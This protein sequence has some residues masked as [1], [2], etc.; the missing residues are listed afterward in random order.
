MER[1]NGHLALVKS[2]IYWASHLFER[3]QPGL[4]PG[5][6]LFSLQCA[7]RRW[8]HLF[9][10]ERGFVSCALALAALGLG[11]HHARPP[12]GGACR[13]ARVAE[14]GRS[15]S[16]SAPGHS[17]TPAANSHFKLELDTWRS[18]RSS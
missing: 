13:L 15:S 6:A 2:M 8:R 17:P 11:G 16:Y 4:A 7:P 10:V 14:G 12:L 5:G 18:K 3:L 1:I 9:I